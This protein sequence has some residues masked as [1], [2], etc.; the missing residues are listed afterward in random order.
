M[1]PQVF[2]HDTLE[3][4][5]SSTDSWFVGASHVLPVHGSASASY[6]HSYVDSD[7]LGY[8]F[9]GDIDYFNGFADQSHAEAEL[10]PRHG[11]HQ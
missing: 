4:A 3:A 2:E 6:S 10:F 8:K 7:Y 9:N 5:N 1:I 11:L